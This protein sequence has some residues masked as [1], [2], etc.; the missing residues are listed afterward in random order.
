MLVGELTRSAVVQKRPEDGCAEEEP[1]G[2]EDPT[3][4]RRR[5]DGDGRR[6]RPHADDEAR[7]VG[8]PRDARRERCSCFGRRSPRRV[9]ALCREHRA[10]RLRRHAVTSR[11][12]FDGLDGEHQR[13][14]LRSARAVLALLVRV[15]R[16]L[17]GPLACVHDGALCK[18]FAARNRGQNC[19][20]IG[21][22]STAA[23]RTF[24]VGGLTPRRR[25]GATRSSSMQARRAPMCSSPRQCRRSP[26]R[27]RRTPRSSPRLRPG[28]RP[29]RTTP[30]TS[31]ST[32]KSTTPTTWTSS[33]RRGGRYSIFVS[34]ETTSTRSRMPRSYCAFERR[35]L[36]FMTSSEAAHSIASP[37]AIL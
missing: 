21:T 15:G 6:R 28:L 12:L 32:S 33:P 18:A 35:R 29:G 27:N 13:R 4:P 10:R 30:S 25:L 7:N 36:S 31:S 5:G 24:D 2:E 23:R 26:R 16:W 8:W 34:I 3:R 20:E 19:R 22:S 14:A 9:D 17:G 1:A 37:R 11:A